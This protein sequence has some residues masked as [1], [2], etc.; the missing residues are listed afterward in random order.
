MSSVITVSTQKGGVGKTTTAGALGAALHARGYRVLYVDLDAQANLTYSAGIDAPRITALEILEGTATAA[1]A[2]IATPQGDIIP[3]APALASAEIIFRETGKEYRLREALEPIRAEYDFIILDTPPALGILTIN[4]LTAADRVIIPAQADIYSLQGIGQLAQTIGTI[5]RYTN[6]GL[7][8][9]GL[10][11]TRYNARALLSRDV[12]EM[13]EDTAR[14]L[15]T[16]VYR[17]RIRECIAL[18]EA[19]ARRLDIFTYSP[20]SNAAADYAAF[21]DEFL[22]REEA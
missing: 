10:L 8:I 15:G 13:L 3:A 22:T 18:K 5:K 4:A 14:E 2:R 9:G 1:E 21:T 17:A 12:S 20:R 11:I 16:Q 19:Q 6:Q 7:K